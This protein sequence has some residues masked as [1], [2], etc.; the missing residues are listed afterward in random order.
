MA[1]AWTRSVIFNTGR[2]RNF[3]TWVTFFLFRF[4]SSALDDYGLF[5]CVTLPIRQLDAPAICFPRVKQFVPQGTNHAN[6]AIV[7]RG[8][9]GHYLI[10]LQFNIT[11]IDNVVLRPLTTVSYLYKALLITP[12]SSLKRG[13]ILTIK[14]SWHGLLPWGY[15]KN[16]K[17]SL[18]LKFS[19]RK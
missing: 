10:A 7:L 11:Y 6:D 19:N 9:W 4:K 12:D 14:E 13:N 16:I 17:R 15:A 3:K 8:G 5:N 1:P 2:P 18:L